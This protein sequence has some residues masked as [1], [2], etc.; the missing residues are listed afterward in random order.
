M[1]RKKKKQEMNC[2]H[3]Q[4]L[5]YN[6]HRFCNNFAQKKSFILLKNYLLGH[7][8]V[9]KQKAFQLQSNKYFTNLK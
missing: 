2:K 5:V 6:G 8:W 1:S 7:W 9:S 3:R 4:A